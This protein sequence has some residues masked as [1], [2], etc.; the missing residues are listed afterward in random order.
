MDSGIDKKIEGKRLLIFLFLS[1]GLTWIIFAA[2]IM[3]GMK[4]DGS[5]YAMEQ[6]VGL[7]MLMP[8]GA[9]LLTSM[10]TTEG[11]R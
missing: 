5:D 1:F 3:K 6:F 8:F 4:W 2:A 10:I 9:N 7:G 11:F